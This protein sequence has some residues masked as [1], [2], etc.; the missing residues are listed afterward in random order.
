MLRKIRYF[1]RAAETGSFSLAAQQEYVSAQALTKQINILE[2]ELGGKLFFRSPQGVTLTP[3]GVFAREKYSYVEEL[4]TD[5]TRQVKEYARS[6]KKLLRVGIF[7]ALPKDDVIFP[8]VAWL[9]TSCP[10][11]QVNLEMIELEEG[12]HKLT[13][14]K[15]DL[16]LTNIHEEDNISGFSAYAFARH[17]TKVVVSL[18]HPWAA[19]E[20]VTADDMKS[21]PFIKMQVDNDHYRVPAEESFYQTVP[22]QKIIPARNFE[23]MM[24]LL[25]QCAGF[26]VFPMIFSN[27]DAAKMKAFDYPGRNFTC[28]TA[29]LVRSDQQENRLNNLIGELA[30]EFRL[31]PL[32]E[33]Q[34]ECR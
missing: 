10:N 20:T 30:A 26:A 34:A 16:L 4:L 12:R 1:L 29:L 28:Y 14:R 23:T 33:K 11:Y 7:S 6:N 2:D 32:S 18:R 9:L 31:S 22:C 25:Q 15:L 21:Q 19:K 24:I 8:V 5:A 13:D 17:D 27:M 3:L